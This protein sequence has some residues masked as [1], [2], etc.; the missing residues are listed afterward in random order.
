MAHTGCGAHGGAVHT[1]THGD[2]GGVHEMHAAPV[3]VCTVA[4]ALVTFFGF[5]VCHHAT[6]RIEYGATLRRVRT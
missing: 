1:G 3:P 2:G 6:K 5:D 4:S